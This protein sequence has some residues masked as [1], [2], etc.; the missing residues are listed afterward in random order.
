VAPIPSFLAKK[1]MPKEFLD[2]FT[3]IREKGF[4]ADIA[5]VRQEYPQ[6]LTLAGWVKNT[7]T[8][9]DFGPANLSA[10]KL[11]NLGPHLI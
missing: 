3:W 9:T 7:L 4:K 11:R 1:M 8:N 6:L 2:M 10:A 5:K